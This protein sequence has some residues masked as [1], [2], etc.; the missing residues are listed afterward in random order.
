MHLCTVFCTNAKDL[1]RASSFEREGGFQWRRPSEAV[2]S[3][4]LRQGAP[5][6]QCAST[7]GDEN[8]LKIDSLDQNRLQS[9][10]KIEYFGFDCVTQNIFDSKAKEVQDSRLHTGQLMH[11]PALDTSPLHCLD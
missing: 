3:D 8:Q 6:K 10:E 11:D 1:V 7:G 9:I 4:S 5:A 2:F